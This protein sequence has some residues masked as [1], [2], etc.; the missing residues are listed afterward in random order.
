MILSHLYAVL[1]GIERIISRIP[2]LWQVLSRLDR[3]TLLQPGT[4]IIARAASYPVL[5]TPS[6]PL[7]CDGVLT[8]GCHYRAVRSDLAA[9]FPAANFI[10]IFLARRVP[11]PPEFE[12]VEDEF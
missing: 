9:R 10:G 7:V 5:L 3:S 6:P 1:L 12:P 2:S 4:S 8:T 11:Q